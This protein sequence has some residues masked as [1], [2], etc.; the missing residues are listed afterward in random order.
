MTTRFAR[1]LFL[2]SF[3]TGATSWADVDRAKAHYQTGMK[4][5]NLQDWAS[6]LDEFKAAYLEQ[7]DP[8]FLFNIGQCQRQLGKYEAAS[9]SFRLYLAQSPDAPNREQAEKLIEDTKAAAE[10]TSQQAVIP[11]PKTSELPS[12]KTAVSGPI[13]RPHIRLAGFVVGS[14]GVATLGAGTGLAIASEEAGNAAYHPQSGVYD[15]ASDDRQK[16]LRN[17]DIV[18]FAIG[19]AA[20]IAG[21]TL[22]LADNHRSTSA[23][24]Q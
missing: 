15:P 4:A 8:A 24:R 18:C 20:V 22:V 2:L 6:A 13:H 10:H 11:T 23:R 14:I 12:L 7:A 19:G 16:Q 9:K 21:L 17:A 5:Y 1:L 3:F